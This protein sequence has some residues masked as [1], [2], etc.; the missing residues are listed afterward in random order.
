MEKLSL[1][2]G[3][4][5]LANVLFSM[6]G[7]NKVDFF[8]RYKFHIGKIRRGEYWRMFTSGFLHA[9]WQHLIFNMLTLYFFADVVLF[10]VGKVGFLL[11]YL[12]ALYLGSL[13]S[14]YFHR[15]ETHYTAVGASGAVMGILYAAIM[16]AP[17]NYIYVF[18][19][20]MP[21]YVFAIGYLF[22]SV[23]GMKSRRDNIGHAAH[24]GGAVAGYIIAMCYF[25]KIIVVHPIL[26][27]G[28]LLPIGLLFLLK[29]KNKI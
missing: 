25:P 29:N 23:Y 7:F 20:P 26:S 12:V 21:A 16:F 18:F 2:T 11:I 6:Q 9:D 4:V 27:V 10:A 13:F 1:I 15:K 3:G 22:Y 14:L 28:L 17:N 8:D 5:I 19:I 24:I